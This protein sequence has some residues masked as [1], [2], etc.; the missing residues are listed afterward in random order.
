LT[1]AIAG[2]GKD[3]PAVSASGTTGPSSTTAGTSASTSG[4][5]GTNGSTSGGNAPTTNT[6]RGGTGAQPG[7]QGGFT[8]G[9]FGDLPVPGGS[10]PVNA[11]QETGSG[12]LRSWK[13]TGK[14]P[15]QVLDFYSQQLPGAGW[16]VANGPGPS[17]ATDWAGEW[18]RGDE[19]LRVTASPFNGDAH[20][21][22]LNLQLING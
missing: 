14:T 22:Q 10:Q 20:V 9:T 15:A 1:L 3:S 11:P 8:S 16:A 4:A 19:V 12:T 7:Q 5:S 17:G 21:T 18:A 2:C 6:T 13:V